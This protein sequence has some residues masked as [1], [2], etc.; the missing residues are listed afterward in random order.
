MEADDIYKY[1]GLFIIV[2]FLLYVVINVLKLQVKALEGFTLPEGLSESKSIMDKK[3]T[4]NV[5]TDKNKVPDAIKSNT[6]NVQDALSIDKY[7]KAYED[8]IVDLYINT[9]VFILSQILTNAENISADPGSDKN[10]KLMTT[11]NNAKEFK[12]TLNSAIVALN[13]NN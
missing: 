7:S 2:V 1:V 6:A 4:T 9:E 10:Q 5:T 3:T 13:S 8:T 11:L 12:L